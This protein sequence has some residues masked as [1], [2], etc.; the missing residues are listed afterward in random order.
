MITKKQDNEFVLFLVYDDVVVAALPA[1]L[2]PVALAVVAVLVVAP[3][4]TL[5]R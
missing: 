2:P 1:R 5:D 4:A 3:A